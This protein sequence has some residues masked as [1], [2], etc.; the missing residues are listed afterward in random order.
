[1]RKK[2][3]R[4]EQKMSDVTETDMV[5]VSSLQ[6]RALVEKHLTLRGKVAAI[7]WVGKRLGFGP[8]TARRIY[9]GNLKTITAGR[10]EA[11]RRWY[12]ECLE[13]ES[14]KTSIKR[15]TV[16]LQIE[17]HDHAAVERKDKSSS[18]LARGSD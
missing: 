6:F 17:G 14:R 13:A 1:M 2:I 4:S 5:G 11:I 9:D 7:E 18:V 12:Q 15:E 8:H 16:R 10:Y 3:L